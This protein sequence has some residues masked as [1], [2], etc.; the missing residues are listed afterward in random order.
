MAKNWKC[1]TI[2]NLLYRSQHRCEY[3]GFPFDD[4]VKGRRF[5]VDHV[6]PKTKG[7]SDEI[8]NLKAACSSCNTSKGAKTIEEFRNMLQRRYSTFTEEQIEVLRIYGIEL[9]EDL[10]PGKHI[11]HFELDVKG[12]IYHEEKAPF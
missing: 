1:K 8:E 12:M 3:C 9:P 11:F 7:G 2:V 4:R 6:V 5:T 10:K